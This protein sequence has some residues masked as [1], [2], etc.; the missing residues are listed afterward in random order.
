MPH[1]VI[2]LTENTRLTCSQEE[3]L[4]EANAALLA[5]GQFQEPDIKSRCVTLSTYR[6]GTE[7]VDR[8]FVHAT[9]SILDGRDQAVRKQLAEIVCNAITEAVRPG[10]AGQNVQV[11]VTVREMERA[12]FAKQIIGN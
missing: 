12:T 1:L 2:E 8:A 6:Q 5:S 4:D 7:N 9:L 3:L 11:T 10:A